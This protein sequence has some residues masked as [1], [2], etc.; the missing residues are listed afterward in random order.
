[1]TFLY[2]GAIILAVIF[3]IITLHRKFLKV[4]LCKENSGTHELSGQFKLGSSSALLPNP[5]GTNQYRIT[6]NKGQL[7]LNHSIY[8]PDGGTWTLPPMDGKQGYYDLTGNGTYTFMIH[9]DQHY[10]EK[11]VLSLVNTGFHDKAEFSY[12]V[13]P[14]SQTKEQVK[15]NH[16][17]INFK[18][19]NGQGFN[20]V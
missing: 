9:I 1:M 15:E 3:S 8:N 2:V 11:D 18:T 16:L 6:V 7:R 19:K 5:I 14:V 4:I 13:T 17:K 10:G 20:K 12:C